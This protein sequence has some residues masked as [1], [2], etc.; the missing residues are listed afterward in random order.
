MSELDVV[1]TVSVAPASVVLTSWLP[2]LTV[3]M[4]S[5]ALAQ[6]IELNELPGAIG[7]A[8]QLAPPS[9][10][11]SSVPGPIAYALAASTKCSAVTREPGGSDT[12]LHDTPP[13][14]VA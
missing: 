10:E 5:E 12:G 6:S 13:S 14:G 8:C 2:A 9:V 7:L 3:R 11:R 4:H 1:F